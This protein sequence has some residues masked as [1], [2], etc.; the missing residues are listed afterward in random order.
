M[1]RFGHDRTR[2]TSCK[3]KRTNASK[4]VLLQCFKVENKKW[5]VRPIQAPLPALLPS[6][7]PSGV[8]L[9]SGL[10]GRGARPEWPR[11]GVV[12]GE[13]AASPPPA[14]GSGERCKLPQ[15][16]EWGPGRSTS[17][18]WFWCFLN[19]AERLWKAGSNN[20]LAS[21]QLILELVCC[22]FL[23]MAAVYMFLQ[24]LNVQTYKNEKLR[25]RFLVY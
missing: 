19:L 9:F 23:D 18:C 13:G 12:L 22:H 25:T 24:L 16:A 4:E 21:K 15:W 3:L 5:P 17:R 10:G 11:R 14:R 7:P 1:G 6:L 2:T 20:C 8:D